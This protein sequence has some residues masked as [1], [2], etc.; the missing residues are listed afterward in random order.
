MERKFK[1]VL[2]WL[3]VSIGGVAD[4]AVADSAPSCPAPATPAEVQER[5]KTMTALFEALDRTKPKDINRAFESFPCA[6]S[7]L[8]HAQEKIT[9]P[10]ER[11]PAIIGLSVASLRFDETNAAVDTVIFDYMK[12]PRVYEAEIERQIRGS[13]PERTERL[14]RLLIALRAWANEIKTKKGITDRPGA[15]K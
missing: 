1:L 6:M 11:V 10:N 12:N 8:S 3:M 4:S 2:V 5:I 7:L 13:K 15:A 9:A 14:N